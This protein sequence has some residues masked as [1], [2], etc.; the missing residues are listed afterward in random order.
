MY[1]HNILLPQY[2]CKIYFILS[3]VKY[4]IFNCLKFVAIFSN[5]ICSNIVLVISI[6]FITSITQMCNLALN[7]ACIT[8]ITI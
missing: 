7:F 2:T 1:V 4:N 3:F 6:F 8:C 5:K